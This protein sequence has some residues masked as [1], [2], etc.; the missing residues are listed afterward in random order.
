MSANPTREQ[1]EVLLRALSLMRKGRGLRATARVVKRDPST[2]RRS[3]RKVF[4]DDLLHDTPAS[5]LPHYPE[6]LK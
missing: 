5:V 1:D 3:M 4:E 6:S 2:L